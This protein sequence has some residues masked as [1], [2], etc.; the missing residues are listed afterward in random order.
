MTPAKTSGHGRQE[1][2]QESADLENLANV[3]ELLAQLQPEQAVGEMAVLAETLQRLAE[4]ISGGRER[5]S[6]QERHVA[7]STLRLLQT[8]L[9]AVSALIEQGDAVCREW[10]DILSP[11][12]GYGA[13]GR[14]HENS[15]SRELSVSG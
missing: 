3:R 12:A 14:L 2:G 15:S 5:M 7:E 13:D 6:L 4:R 1:H 11:P 8:E 9:A 10:Q